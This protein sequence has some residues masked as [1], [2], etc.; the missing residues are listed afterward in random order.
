MK[1]LL[2]TKLF[3]PQPLPD[4]VERPELFHK[5][6]QG[7][8]RQL[9]LVSA[10]A[11]Y[12][13]SV[14]VSAWLEQCTRP[15]AWLSL[16]KGDD[17]L[18]MFCQYVVAA[19]EA[20]FPASC[21][22]TSKLLT[23]SQVPSAQQLAE[24]FVDDLSSIEQSFVFVLEDFGFIHNQDIHNLIDM[25]VAYCPATMQLVVTTRRDPSFNLQSL[26]ASGRMSEVRQ[27]DLKFTEV[28]VSRFFQNSMTGTLDPT[29]TAAL[30][31][32]VEGWAA[33]LRLILLSVDAFKDLEDTVREI[34]GSSGDIKEYLISEVLNHLPA[35]IRRSLLKT[36]ILNRFNAD[37]CT[38]F[39]GGDIRDGEAF[40][41]GI[42]EAN[43]FCIPL[44]GKKQWYRY[45]HLFQELLAV[46]LERRYD[47]KEIDELHRTAAK[48]YDE[49]GFIEDAIYHHSQAGAFTEALDVLENHRHH[50][51][52]SEQ[53][54]RLAQ[55]ISLLPQS[56]YSYYP[57]VLISKAFLAENRFDIGEALAA[58]E[59][60]EQLYTDP[61]T[62]KLFTATTIGEKEALLSMKCYIL[63]EPGQGVKHAERAIK[64]L[65]PS[66]SSVLGFATILCALS[67]QLQGNLEEANRL[68]SH[69]LEQTDL[70]GP[71]Y[72]GRI[73]LAFCFIYWFSGDLLNLKLVATEYLRFAEEHQLHEAR[74]FALYFLGITAFQEN[75]LEQAETF[76]T[77]GRN[78]GEVVN[79]NSYAQCSFVLALTCVLNGNIIQAN[80]IAE[81]VVQKAYQLG[82]AGLLA[83]AK[84]FQIE[85]SLR[86]GRKR[87]AEQWLSQLKSSSISPVY[88]MYSPYITEVKAGLMTDSEKLTEQARARIDE[89]I[90]FFRKTHHLP[91]L[92]ELHA[93]AAIAAEKQKLPDIADEHCSQA[94][95]IGSQGRFIGLFRS[96]GSALL[97]LLKRQTG[98]E[99]NPTYLEK[100]SSTLT[101][102]D[103]LKSVGTPR[104][105]PDAQIVQQTTK[106]SKWKPLSDR[107][108]EILS[109][110]RQRLS[111]KEIASELYISINTV[112]R[113]IINI[114]QKLEVHNRREAVAKA[115][116]IDLAGLS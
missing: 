75:Y 55:I 65:P 54:S 10:P 29:V 9:T 16:A 63:V 88:R 82:N 94:L 57:G 113:H 116:E 14:T 21:A 11:G 87:P 81:Q 49:H 19:L 103:R 4:F 50:L 23:G 78:L 61:K 36:A 114:Y 107:E 20:I 58:I 109:L 68:L 92:I 38:R 8:D 1:K 2:A 83:T 99:I 60:I 90:A 28:E 41:A 85:L 26:R 44:D 70:A 98:Q 111:N 97:P 79:I 53:W 6:D 13:K 15:Y 52:N 39:L 3:R 91:M 86:E 35:K 31:Q 77:E 17:D 48:W 18:Y 42:V 59:D 80:D 24:S 71:T 104:S 47:K 46:I 32:R 108:L 110:L 93:L 95:R 33:G 7:K 76:L 69:A 106:G 45:H 84:A 72:K 96:V 5:L 62:R 43:L 30:C 27:V 64:N 25:V 12:G 101:P 66:C 56:H 105:M 100:I 34:R 89:L 74:C 40:L 112:K 115:E 37:L 67:H 73:F 51:M 102:P 22:K